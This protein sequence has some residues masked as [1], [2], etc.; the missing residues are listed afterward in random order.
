MKK[1]KRECHSVAS[2][3]VKAPTPNDE[4]YLDDMVNAVL[5]T[6][7]PNA[8][9]CH[10]KKTVRAHVFITPSVTGADRDGIVGDVTIDY[11]LNK[12][13][14]PGEHVVDIFDE[15]TLFLKTNEDVTV[16]IPYC[17]GNHWLT[18]EIKIQKRGLY[19]NTDIQL[20]DPY[21]GSKLSDGL[22]GELLVSIGDRLK[23]KVPECVR[24]FTNSESRFDFRR[25]AA[26]DGVSCGV[27]V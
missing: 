12:G 18:C 13:K 1:R 25:Q 2:A 24:E 21:G 10:T 23:E 4:M 14:Q 6:T 11:Y 16:L 26:D 3:P 7:V 17:T 9:F 8:N 5:G 19:I 22:F 27:I 15:Q 20:H